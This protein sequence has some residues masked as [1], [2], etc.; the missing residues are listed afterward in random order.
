MGDGERQDSDDKLVNLTSRLRLSFR[1]ECNRQPILCVSKHSLPS[2]LQELV[3]AHLPALKLA[4]LKGVSRSWRVLL[5][6]PRFKEKWQSIR[7]GCNSD[8]LDV[9]VMKS[10]NEH[11][12]LLAY[13]PS[14]NKYGPFLQLICIP[15]VLSN[16]YMDQSR[17]R[18]ILR[19]PVLIAAE[20][21]SQFCLVVETNAQGPPQAY[22]L[23][24]YKST[25]ASWISYPQESATEAGFGPRSSIDFCHYNDEDS[26]LYAWSE[27]HWF[28]VHV[29]F[30]I[31]E[32]Q[33]VWGRAFKDS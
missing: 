4:E 10:M 23:L 9:W 11:D 12:D 31:G 30:P 7:G 27:E 32:A 29:T 33:N 25:T 5:R 28:K 18:I 21:H 20:D 24:V 13:I 19:P 6:S 22:E 16:P 1:S 15:L 8:Y 17:S 3:L 2:E 26:T 14:L